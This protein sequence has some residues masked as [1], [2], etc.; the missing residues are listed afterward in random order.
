MSLTLAKTLKDL[1]VETEEIVKKTGLSRNART[2]FLSR[3]A[4][5]RSIL[6][7]DL[8]SI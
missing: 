6:S 2:L 3:I 7:P 8:V 4:V 1:G 5:I